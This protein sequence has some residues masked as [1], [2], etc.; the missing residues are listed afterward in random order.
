VER[1]PEFREFPKIPRWSREVIISEK[2]DGCNGVVHVAADGVVTAGSRNRW[3]APDR[4]NHGFA[5]WVKEHEV[6]LRELGEGYHHGEWW[7]QR[8]QRGYCLTEKRWS[9]LNTSK[10]TDSRPKC[11][12]VVPILYKGMMSENAIMGYLAQL[13][14]NGSVAAPGFMKPEGIVIFHV[15][16]NLFFKKTLEND[17]IPKSMIDT[18]PSEKTNELGG[19]S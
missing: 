1:M 15:Q 3:L 18:I 2:I 8:I 9:L 14:V 16:G 19:P 13:A 12:H 11:C 6:E 10:W 4:D 17:E 7:G 5:K